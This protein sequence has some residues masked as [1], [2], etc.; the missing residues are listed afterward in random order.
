MSGGVTV[1]QR[2]YAQSRGVRPGAI[3]QAVQD[4]RIPAGADGRIDPEQADATWFRRHRQQIE[5]RQISAE[6][7]AR[8]EHALVQSTVAKIQM[9]RRRVERLRARLIERD[10]GQAAIGALIERL[11][12]A[13]PGFVDNADAADVALLR[14]VVAIVAAE[15]GDLHAE[16]LRM[17]RGEAAQRE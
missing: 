17:M 7:E 6:A 1:S 9:T 8:R 11:H 2:E 14:D 15:L 13:L 10:K 4:G 12:A 3:W 5:A 16:A